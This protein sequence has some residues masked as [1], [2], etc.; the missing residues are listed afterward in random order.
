MGK[1]FR[2]IFIRTIVGAYALVVVY[3]MSGITINMSVLRAYNDVKPD[4]ASG[5]T[6]SLNFLQTY[7]QITGDVTLA[8][9][10]GFS[11]EDAEDMVAGGS[12]LIN[13][14]T[15]VTASDS[16]V[17]AANGRSKEEIIEALD[18]AKKSAGAAG[19]YYTIGDNWRLT[20]VNG[21]YYLVEVQTSGK[22]NSVRQQGFSDTNA[23]ASVGAS[24]CFAFACVNAINAINNTTVSVSNALDVLWPTGCLKDYETSYSYSNT[25]N[26][27]TG[28]VAD[29]NQRNN[30]NERALFAKYGLQEDYKVT[31][32]VAGITALGAKEGNTDFNNSVYIFY[33][34]RT[35][36][37]TDDTNHWLVCVA[38][39]ADSIYVLGDNVSD[40][41]DGVIVKVDK[42]ILSGGDITTV[43]KV[44]K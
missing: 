44:H 22:W 23:N 19:D 7:T 4:S 38:A 30:E 21:K 29:L 16:T 12:S 20:E 8:V 3:I 11:K 25:A 33:G 9:K 14:I 15:G 6:K 28:T 18:N 10:K 5:F 17:Y 2:K 31:Q 27:W 42:S 36:V 34:H 40:G 1:K 24:G 13:N 43:I 39:D 41:K 37:F 35:G 32:G 26:K